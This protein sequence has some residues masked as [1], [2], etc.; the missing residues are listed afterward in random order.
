MRN[1]KTSKKKRNTY[2]YYGADGARIEVTPGMNGVLDSDIKILHS[3][4]DEEVDRER[5]YD[6]RIKYSLNDVIHVGDGRV[7][8]RMDLIQDE[9]LDPLETLLAALDEAEKTERLAKLHTALKTLTPLQRQTL[10]KKFVQNRTNV[11]IAAEEGVS[12]MAITNRLKKIV[13]KLKRALEK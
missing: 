4:D 8:E 10:E 13:A 11:D 9:N 3:W 1:F 2:I 6:Y 7:T 12:K 5:R